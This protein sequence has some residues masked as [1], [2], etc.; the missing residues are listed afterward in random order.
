MLADEI[1]RAK[2]LAE[3]AVFDRH[4]RT[5]HDAIANRYPAPELDAND[6]E[7]LGPW[8]A[9]CKESGIR[10]APAKPWCVAVF[11]RHEKAQCVAEHIILAR[12]NAIQ[13]LHD[14][15]KLANPVATAIVNA[16]LDEFTK[17]PAPRS[18]TKEEQ[19]D[20]PLLPPIIKAAIA[21]RGERETKL[22]QL[23]NQVADLKKQLKPD[24]P[25]EAVITD[26][27]VI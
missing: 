27:K 23:Q 12:C 8:L 24:A 10:H 3:A 7:L 4:E 13:K 6:K 2:Q 14:K 18:W 9:F 22:R 21:R 20:W 25:K 17:H 16:V 1:E 26:E 15:Y 5:I 19:R 11:I